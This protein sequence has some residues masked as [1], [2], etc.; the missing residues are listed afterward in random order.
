MLYISSAVIYDIICL[1][2]YTR[3]RIV[4]CDAAISLSRRTAITLAISTD[5]S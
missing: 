5:S 4:K 2:W 3:G 1:L